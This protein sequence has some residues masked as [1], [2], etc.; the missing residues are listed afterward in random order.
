EVASR[1]ALYRDPLHP[2]TRL[3]LEAAPPPDPAKEKQREAALIRGELPSPFA[4]PS[5]CPVRTR[6]PSADGECA[7]AVPELRE[8]RPGHRVACLK[9]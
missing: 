6:G 7:R 2:Y 3:L 1:E 8:V 4:P 9:L 5:G